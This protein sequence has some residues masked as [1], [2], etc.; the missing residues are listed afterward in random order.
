MPWQLWRL[1]KTPPPLP[2]PATDRESLR[3]ELRQLDTGELLAL[4]ARLQ[5]SPDRLLLY[6]GVLRERSGN[7]AQLAACL[8]CFDL[9]RL[10]HPTAQREFYALIPTIHS[11]ASDP[12]AVA[13]LVEDDPFLLSLWH[14][15]RSAISRDDPRDAFDGLH[16]RVELVGELDLLSD[17]D[18][19][20]ELQDELARLAQSAHREEH[21]AAFARLTA[22]QLGY[23]LV[24][25]VMPTV[26]GLS[27]GT[28][29]QLDRLEEYL[30]QASAY[31]AN[32]PLARGLACLGRLF[33][34]GHLRRHRLFGRPN[35]RRVEA[36]RE[37]L[38][39][40][41][42][43]DPAPLVEAAALIEEEGARVVASFQKATELLLDFLRYCS[44][45]SLDPLENEAVDSYVAADRL[46]TP[47]LLSGESRRRR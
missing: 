47:M 34:A 15:C 8:V 31:A 12:L 9:A 35:P 38:G 14:G 42:A 46:P 32:V 6:L 11:L 29:G 10:G 44:Q 24:N 4:G 28:A 41:P 43:D 39:A 19:G 16:T 26:S 22:R 18:L 40:L 36:L 13:E 45:N 25:D 27:T 17:L 21:E 7:R 1:V 30:E 5:R 33:L 23:D 3:S 2:A 20:H 37:G